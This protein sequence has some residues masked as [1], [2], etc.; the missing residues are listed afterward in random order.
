MK[1]P[2]E[3]FEEAISKEERRAKRLK[4]PAP[5]RGDAEALYLDAF[6]STRSA[7]SLFY[8]LQ[9]RFGYRR[10]P[11]AKLARGVA[12]L[13]AEQAKQ[14]IRTLGVPEKWTVDCS[15]FGW[16]EYGKQ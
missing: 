8:M 3:A 1:S 10:V 14:G 16:S 6:V 13:A 11:S 7:A 2:R 12:E 15:Q 5:N 4:L 9:R